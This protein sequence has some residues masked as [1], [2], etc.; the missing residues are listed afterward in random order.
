M[1]ALRGMAIAA[2][3]AVL[4][5]AGYTAEAQPPTVG[6]I[7]PSALRQVVAEAAAEM[8]VPGAMVLV[9]TPAGTIETAVGTTVRGESLTPTPVT[10]FRI[11]SNTKTMTA[12]LTML[13]VQDG[14]LALGD[15]VSRYVDGVPDGENITI[16]DLLAMRSGL[17]GYTDDPALAEE[18]D[19]DPARRYTPADVLAIAYRHPSQFPPGSDYQYSNT[20]Y[21]LLG[22][23]AEQVGGRPLAEQFRGR[24]FAPLGLAA[25]SLPGPDD[26]TIAA[27]YAHGYMYGGTAYALRDDPYPAEMADAARAGTLAPVDYTHQNPSYAI[28]AGGAISTAADLA[29]WIEALVTGTVFDAETHR[30]WV[31]GLQPED[32]AH[33]EGQQ[34]GYGI[35]HQRFGPD[36]AMFYHGG[37]LPGFNSFMGHDPENAV[38]LVI[39]TNLTVAPDG[40]TTANAML[41]A[42]LDQ[43]YPG[44]GLTTG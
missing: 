8:L 7:D 3:C 11:A 16:A 43:I 24:L 10:R 22:L 6:V 39:W 29:T 38:T 26:T 15:P 32:P 1:W 28:A 40:R 14:R 27:P 30:Q 31:A 19:R 33:P 5:T 34:Y 17:Y 9:R 21:A 36:A 4:S 12:A 41:P 35:A 37:E 44:L 42:V 20:N 23:V 25:T 18:L 13:L 2:V